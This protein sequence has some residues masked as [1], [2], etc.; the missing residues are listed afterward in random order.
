MKE[1]GTLALISQSH[2]TCARAWHRLS[3]Q[4]NAAAEPCCLAGRVGSQQTRVSPQGWWAP[5]LKGTHSAIRHM[6]RAGSGNLP[7]N[8]NPTSALLPTAVA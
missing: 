4:R 1:E 7:P 2:A 5:Q 6:V 3:N 8:R